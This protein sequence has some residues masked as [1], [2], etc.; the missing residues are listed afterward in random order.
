MSTGETFRKWHAENVK[1]ITIRFNLAGDK[2]ILDAIERR[3]KSGTESRSAIM[4]AW[5]RDGI[6]AEEK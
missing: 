4:K 6:E 3:M 1:D 5:L 2:D